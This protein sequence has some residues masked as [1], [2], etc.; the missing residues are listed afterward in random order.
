[1]R[2]VKAAAQVAR[3]QAQKPIARTEEQERRV[4]KKESP[5]PIR[6]EIEAALRRA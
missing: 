1:M 2:P 4:T 6:H 5:I 3:Q